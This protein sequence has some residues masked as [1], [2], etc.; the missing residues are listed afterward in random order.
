MQRCGGVSGE[1]PGLHSRWCFLS[2]SGV[3]SSAW[4]VALVCDLPLLA[5]KC[6]RAEENIHPER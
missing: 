3:P 4:A 2:P 5:E 6:K 1:G